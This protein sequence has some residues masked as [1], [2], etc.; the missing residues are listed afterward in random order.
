MKSSCF[1]FAGRSSYWFSNQGTNFLI[2]WSD[3]NHIYRDIFHMK[4]GKFGDRCKNSMQLTF[5]ESGAKIYAEKFW[6]FSLSRF[7]FCPAPEDFGKLQLSILNEKFNFE[8][9]WRKTNQTE[10]YTEL[11]YLKKYFEF[12]FRSSKLQK[13]QKKKHPHLCQTLKKA[14]L[15][16]FWI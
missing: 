14:C 8:E 6:Q 10:K 1:V 15:I 12:L 9:Q 2:I 4:N 16:R 11:P 7:S 5:W 13:V 3:S